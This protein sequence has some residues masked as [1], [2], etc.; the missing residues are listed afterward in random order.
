MRLLAAVVVPWM[1]MPNLLAQMMNRYE[2]WGAVLSAMLI[3]ISSGLGLLHVLVTLVAAGMI[4]AQL[5]AYD[6]ARSPAL[7]RVLTAVMPS[8][9][10]LLLLA[11]VVVLVVAVVPGR[12]DRRPAVAGRGHRRRPSSTSTVGSG[13]T[14]GLA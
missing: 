3:G 2:M 12:R 6:P 11:A 9:A 7:Q 14:S 1:L 4:G 5:L 10:G 13:P 8:E